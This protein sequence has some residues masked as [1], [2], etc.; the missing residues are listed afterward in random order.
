MYSNRDWK[1]DDMVRAERDMGH[2]VDQA[3][4]AMHAADDLLDE[5]AA[6]EEKRAVEHAEQCREYAHRED[7]SPAWQKVVEK[8]DAGELTWHEIAKGDAMDHPA[9]Q[10]AIAGDNELRQ[11]ESGTEELETE[12]DHRNDDDYYDDFTV[13]GGRS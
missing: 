6:N 7:V 3:Y 11:R 4:R 5:I 12:V 10:A 13:Y 9:L 2:V 8:V 1:T